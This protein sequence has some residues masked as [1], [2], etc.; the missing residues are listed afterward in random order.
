MSPRAAARRNPF[1]EADI[2]LPRMTGMREGVRRFPAER[3]NVPQCQN[4]PVSWKNP[5]NKM[6]FVCRYN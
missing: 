6:I 3:P 2:D 1:D 4:K 5:V